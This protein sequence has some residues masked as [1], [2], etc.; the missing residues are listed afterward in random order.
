MSKLL[1]IGIT[2][3]IGSG[4]SYICRIFESLGYKI[5]YAD[6][7]AKSLMYTDAQLVAEVKD[8][9]G[10]RAYTSDEKLDR[11]YV[12]GIVFNDPDKLKE[13]NAL[14]HPAVGRDFYRW[15]AE[16]SED[17][18]H[19]FVLKEAAIMYESGSYKDADAVI[20]VYAPKSVR[21]ERVLSRESIS[22][23][24]V[25]A[26]MA[27]QWPESEK[28]KRADFTIINDGKHH[29]LPQIREIIRKYS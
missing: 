19:S 1:K 25:L 3:G 10:E 15:Y 4:K 21:L 14:V 24:A 26:R 13:L 8:L 23:E 17:Y 27:Q 11:A 18:P 28:M 2:G 9:L 16:I 12:G 5:Y 22:E 7:Q 29:L 6:Q 20:T